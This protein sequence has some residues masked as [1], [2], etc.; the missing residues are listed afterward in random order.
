V[1][2]SLRDRLFEQRTT[3]LAA[4]SPG[5][6]SDISHSVLDSESHGKANALAGRLGGFGCPEGL[7]LESHGKPD[8]VGS[9]DDDLLTTVVRHYLESADFNGI[10]LSRLAREVSLTEEKLRGEL[11]DGVR[12]GHVGVLVDENPHI[13]RLPLPSIELQLEALADSSSAPCVYPTQRSLEERVP[14]THLADRPFSRMLALGE[15]QFR[16]CFF[17]LQVLET[18]ANEPGYDLRID[19]IAGALSVTKEGW[20]RLPDR[21]R[22]SLQRFGFGHRG[23]DMRRVVA[24]SLRDLQG[25]TPEH[26]VVWRTRRIDRDCSLHPQYKDWLLGRWTSS[27]SVCAALLRLLRGVNRVCEA[28]GRRPLFRNAPREQPR[29]FQFLWRPTKQAYDSFVHAADK[30][31]SENIDTGFFGKEIERFRVEERGDGTVERINKGSIAMLEDWLKKQ[32]GDDERIRTAIAPIRLVRRQR[33]E[34]AHSLIQ[35]EFNE[36]L[37]DKQVEL[38][39]ELEAGLRTLLDLLQDQLLDER[40]KDPEELQGIPIHFS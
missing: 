33:Q 3:R 21:D 9:S 8:R 38:M 5:R 22:V 6:A 12:R 4:V 37:L 26:Q 1:Q 25:L 35:N 24:V 7:L 16:H 34:P 20:G 23:D 19:D 30:L 36:E 11:A 18:Y 15:H 29:D 28:A 14:S 2:I 13:L 39:R 40:L 17:E 31:L 27:V 32:A 10:P